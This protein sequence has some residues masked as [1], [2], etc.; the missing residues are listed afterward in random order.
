L[1]QPDLLYK[2]F[3]NERLL[4][5]GFLARC[6]TADSKMQVQYEDERTLAEADPE[7]MSGW[8][9]HITSLVET[10]RFAKDPRWIAVGDRVRKLSRTFYNETV[11]QIRDTLSDVSNFA[12]RWTERAWE[13]A[14]NLHVGHHGAQ[15]HQQTLNATTFSNA[16]RIARFFTDRQLEVLQRPR[17][18]AM[19]EQ[20]DRLEEILTRNAREPIT[21]RDLSRRHGIDQNEVISSVKSNPKLFGMVTRRPRHGGQKSPILFLQSNPPPGYNCYRRT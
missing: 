2:A 4:V 8:N 13:L 6:L 18:K 1:V 5:G 15:S 17:I 11:D 16:L 12:L 7:I 21:L 10:F 19:N 9:Q 14:L 3:G 20:R